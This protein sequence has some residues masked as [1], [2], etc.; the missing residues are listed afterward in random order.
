MQDK[1]LEQRLR[2]KARRRGYRLEKARGQQHL[3]NRGGYQIINT[4]RNEV[5]AGDSYDILLHELA[6]WLDHLPAG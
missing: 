3:N 1:A 5:V 6:G 4:W 2:R